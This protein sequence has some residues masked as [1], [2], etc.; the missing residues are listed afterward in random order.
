[1]TLEEICLKPSMTSFWTKSEQTYF[2]LLVASF[3]YATLLASFRN[4][5]GVRL[6]RNIFW[7]DQVDIAKLHLINWEEVKTPKSKEGLGLCCAK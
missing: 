3:W 4:L 5:E 1:M 2:T 7:G 6:N